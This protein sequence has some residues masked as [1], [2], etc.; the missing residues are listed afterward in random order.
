MLE[1]ESFTIEKKQINRGSNNEKINSTPVRN[2][3][4]VVIMYIAG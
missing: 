2:Y 4:T 1:I 3:N